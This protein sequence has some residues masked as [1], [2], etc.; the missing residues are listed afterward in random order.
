MIK[1]ASRI[2]NGS[3]GCMSSELGARDIALLDYKPVSRRV[4]LMRHDCSSSILATCD[5]LS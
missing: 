1:R 4:Q 3:S 5:Q 2:Q